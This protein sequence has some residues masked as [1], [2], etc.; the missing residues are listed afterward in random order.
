MSAGSDVVLWRLIRSLHRERIQIISGTEAPQQKDQYHPGKDQCLLRW[1]Q[2][3]VTL[4]TCPIHL[5]CIAGFVMDPHRCLCDLCPAPVFLAELRVHVRRP[6]VCVTLFAVLLMK[7]RQIDPR[8]CQ[9]RMDIL[10]IRFRI[11]DPACSSLGKE[12]VF[13]HRVSHAF[14][15]RPADTFGFCC[16]QSFIDGVMGTV[17]HPLHLSFADVGVFAQP[18]HVTVVNQFGYLLKDSHVCDVPSFIFVAGRE[19]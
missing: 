5:H 6:V 17:Q 16:C 18:Q 9:F 14:I 15:K 1:R 13:Q 19:K 12:K 7:D 11:D 2:G 3:L 8:S 4:I 10:V